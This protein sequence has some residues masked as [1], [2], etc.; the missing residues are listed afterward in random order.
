MI[1]SVK[2]LLK[3]KYIILILIFC[4]MALSL[5]GCTYT[6]F[7]EEDFQ[8]G[9]SSVE[10]VGNKVI[11]E[12]IF[13]NKTAHS[14][15]IIGGG[16]EGNISSIIDFEYIDENGESKFA[17]PD[18]AIF[19]YVKAKQKVVARREFNLEP[20]IYTIMCHVRF[21][22]NGKS[23]LKIEDFSDCFYY[24]TEGVTVEIK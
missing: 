15:I 22:C 21:S 8:L 18:I 3:R 5:A 20:G 4:L 19:H 24:K 9:I 12:A 14:G 10:V 7:K 17:F 11:V 2:K 23:R 6:N 13:E 16:V 1:W